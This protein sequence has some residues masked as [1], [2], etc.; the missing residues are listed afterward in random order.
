M[1]YFFLLFM[2][3]ISWGRTFLL[4]QMVL[5]FNIVKWVYMVNL[6]IQLL[7]C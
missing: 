6:C 3:E 1:I 2:R 5:L 7:P 4:I